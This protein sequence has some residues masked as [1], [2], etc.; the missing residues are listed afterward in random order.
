M[1]DYRLKLSDGTTTIDLYGGS[2]SIIRE[3]GLIM[4]P[5]RSRDRYVGNDF[6]D[7]SHLASSTYENRTITLN[8]RIWGSSLADLKTNIRSIQRLL[9]DAK[10]RTLLGY[11]DQVYLEYQWGDSAGASTYFDVLKGDLTLPANYLNVHL[12]TGYMI[13][14]ATI[15]LVCKPFGRYTNQ[16]IAEDTLENSQSA[17]DLIQSYLTG[18]DAIGSIDGDNW[19]GQTFTTASAFTIAGAS[20]MVYRAG[21]ITDLTCEL[22]ATNAGLP[23]GSV[24]ATGDLDVSALS[25]VSNASHIQWVRV[26]FDTPYALSNSTVYAVC[27]HIGESNPNFVYFRYDAGGGVAGGNMVSSADGGSSWASSA[28]SDMLYGLYVAETKANYQDIT[29]SEAYGDIPAN[30]FWRV[31]AGGE[32][33]SKKTWLAKISGDRYDDDLW[34]E[35]EDSTSGDLGAGYTYNNFGT[36]AADVSGGLCGE[37]TVEHNGG[38]AASTALGY[39]YYNFSNTRSGTFR[40]LTKARVICEDSADYDHLSFGLGWTYGGASKTPAEAD[41][42]YHECAADSTWEILD[43]GLINIPPTGDS[44]IETDAVFYALIYF[45]ANQAL[46][47]N[48]YYKL[49]I[50]YIFLL[51]IDEGAVIVDTVANGYQLVSDS[52]SD[53][54]IVFISY[55]NVFY[56]QPNYVGKPFTIGRETTRLYVLRDDTKDVTFAS[57]IKYQPRFLLI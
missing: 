36:V 24:L 1:A 22:Y 39:L 27:I 40:F 57:N 18:D 41:G 19:I 30:M 34:F 6:I 50:D 25:T 3:G 44:G 43:L 7:G 46:T 37:M 38:I 14:N 55:A 26:M 4:P 47:T 13:P 29:T 48:E 5:P 35:G 51:P 32:T 52:I 42:D 54:P 8:T 21:T 53:P 17:Y 49:Q 10:Y 12:K 11:G 45:Y 31:E 9:N 33:G 15:T 20:F 2:D 56:N 16:D 28:P 23:T